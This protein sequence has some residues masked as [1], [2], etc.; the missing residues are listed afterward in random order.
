MQKGK[1]LTCELKNWFKEEKY[2]V[3]LTLMQFLIGLVW[4]VLH[5]YLRTTTH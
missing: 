4:R 5:N 3:L 2:K 1:R